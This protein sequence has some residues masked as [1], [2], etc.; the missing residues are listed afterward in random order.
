VIRKA[1]SAAGYG[2]F[3]V[4][5]VFLAVMAL[6]VFMVSCGGLTRTM[7]NSFTLHDLYQRARVGTSRDDVEVFL[8]HHHVQYDETYHG[9]MHAIAAYDQ[10]G[11]SCMITVIRFDSLRRVKSLERRSVC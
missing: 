5:G 10:A 8:M 4:V 6:L 2:V 7:V 11:V 3:G 1:W 9:D